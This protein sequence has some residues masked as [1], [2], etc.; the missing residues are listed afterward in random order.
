MERIPSC[1]ANRSSASE[2]IP[3]ILRNQ[4]IHY[5]INKSPLSLQI[6]SQINPVHA[7]SYFLK[8]RFNIIHPSTPRSYK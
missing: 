8:I 2:E 3:C 1:E 7:P 5:S 4:K 6:L